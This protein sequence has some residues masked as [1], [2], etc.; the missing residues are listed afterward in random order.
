MMLWEKVN[1]MT[2][3]DRTG[4]EIAVVVETAVVGSAKPLLSVVVVVVLMPV[5]PY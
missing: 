4:R 3:T 5:R 1:K 2:R